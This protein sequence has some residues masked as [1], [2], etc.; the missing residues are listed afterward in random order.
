MAI[1]GIQS[2][3]YGVEDVVES[4]RFLSDFGLRLIGGNAKEALFRLDEGSEV[5]VRSLSD[6][7]IPNS[8]LVGSGV[9]EVVLG[10]DSQSAFDDLVNDLQRDRELVVD[11][12]GTAH[13]L[14]DCGL[15]LGLKIFEKKP[16]C[17]APDPLNAPGVVNRLNTHRKWR[18]R[19]YPKT[20]GHVVFG[21]KDFRK[22]FEFFR[23][24]LHFRLSDYQHGLA[25]YMRADGSNHHHNIALVTATLA[26]PHDGQPRFHHA[27]FGVE[28]IDEVMTGANYMERQ[29]WP[30]SHLGLGRHRLDSALFLYLPCPLGGEIEYGTDSDYIDDRWVPREWRVPLFGYIHHV[31]NLPAWLK[32][33]PEW[34]VRYLTDGQLPAEIKNDR[35][36]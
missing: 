28:D 23:D 26:E 3:T 31:H 16:V 27:N 19:A 10:V 6:P 25:V 5:R 18:L 8:V 35:S 17:N 34:D 12:T 33:P 22:S 30:K 20:I 15:P 4:T 36:K 7:S 1:I 14:S 21:V 24:R 2:M 32:E 9:R 13:F 11:N 29:G